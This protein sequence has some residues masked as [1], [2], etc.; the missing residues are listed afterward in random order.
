MLRRADG[1]NDFACS[2]KDKA[3]IKM[4]DRKTRAIPE[5]DY[6][7]M[8]VALIVL[9]MYSSESWKAVKTLV[10]TYRFSELKF[11]LCE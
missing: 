10:A 8:S 2:R 4:L 7:C 6:T 11:L 3:T 5:I 1:R 9:T